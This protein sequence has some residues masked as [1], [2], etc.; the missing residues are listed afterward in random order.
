M[1]VAP[2][3]P[4]QKKEMEILLDLICVKFVSHTQVWE[5]CVRRVEKKTVQSGT[6]CNKGQ[7]E[8]AG[9]KITMLPL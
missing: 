7:K 1:C 6:K 9:L 8:K 4:K 2:E 3:L 5:T